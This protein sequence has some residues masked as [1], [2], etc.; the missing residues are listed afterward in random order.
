MQNV[1]R[2]DNRLCH[3]VQGDGG[4]GRSWRWYRILA[5]S[6]DGPPGDGRR[7]RAVHRPGRSLR[8]ARHEP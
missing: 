1:D 4:M 7:K 6:C 3:S 2:R 5:T 8:P